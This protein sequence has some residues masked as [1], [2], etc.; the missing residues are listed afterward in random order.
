MDPHLEFLG[1]SFDLPVSRAQ[2]G[3]WKLLGA[4][5]WWSS[6]DQFRIGAQRS[7]IVGAESVTEKFSS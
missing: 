7:P 4:I 1:E 3:V 2:H 5:N 6:F